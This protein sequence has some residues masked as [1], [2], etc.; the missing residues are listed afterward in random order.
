MSIGFQ[1]MFRKVTNRLNSWKWKKLSFAARL[2]L[3]Q[4]VLSTIPLY[5]LSSVHV[6]LFIINQLEKEI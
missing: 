6:P 5:V 3:A 4:F 2:T 1:P